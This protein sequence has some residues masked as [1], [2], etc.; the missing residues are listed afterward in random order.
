MLARGVVSSKPAMREAEATDPYR[1]DPEGVPLESV[2]VGVQQIETL[3]VAKVIPRD[4]LRQDPVLGNLRILVQPQGTVYDVSSEQNARLNELWDDIEPRQETDGPELPEPAATHLRERF[5]AAGR[6]LTWWKTLDRDLQRREEAL[7]EMQELLRRF[8]DGALDVE[9]FREEFDRRSRSRLW[10]EFGFGG[11]SGG[12][13]LNKLVKHLPHAAPLEDALRAAFAEPS[14]LDDA[15]SKL[16]QLGAFVEDAIQIGKATRL[17]LQ[18]ARLP[19]LTSAMWHIHGPF[20]W[21]ASYQSTRSQLGK[22]G[23][24]LG[25]DYGT[26]YRTFYNAE[27]AACHTLDIDSWVLDKLCAWS[28][29]KAAAQTASKSA[30]EPE[31]DPGAR[32][33]LIGSGHLDDIWPKMRDEKL[34]AI[35][36]GIGDLNQ[37]DSQESMK[38]AL[39]PLDWTS[40]NPTNDAKACW[41]FANEIRVGDKVIVKSG[42]TGVVAL[43]TLQSD[44]R[45]DES[46]PY[47]YIRD[48]TWDW[49]GEAELQDMKMVLKALTE[50]TENHALLE[51]VD[52]ATGKA[53]P[54]PSGPSGTFDMEDALRDL[55]MERSDLDMLRARLERKKNLV[56]QGPPGTGKTFVAA[57]LARLM[58]GEVSDER[59][60]RVQFHQS[61]GYEHF[62][63]GFRP[64]A[65]GGFEVR[66]GPFLDFCEQARQDQ[67][68]YW[69]VIIDEIN[70]GNL[71]RI[72]G[73]LL[74]LIE[75]D[76]RSEDWAVE[77]AYKRVR[78]W[79]P[80]N[81]LLIGTMN[82]ADR[83]L[84]LVDYAL[85]RRFAFS[86]LRPAFG[87]S[88]FRRH[89]VERTSDEAFVDRLVERLRAL[90]KLIV[91]DDELGHGFAVGHS[92]F[93]EP[94]G[95]L[96]AWYDD[97]VDSEILPLLREYWFDRSDAVERA[98]EILRRA[99]D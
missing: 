77:L 90:N 17:Q 15:V 37:Y 16:D 97:I 98:E 22:A 5:L 51:A 85:R 21:P 54:P 68:N 48:V 7:G 11:M 19:F 18:P 79:V 63:Q 1:V 91:G 42:R 49:L 29:P 26:F 84:A 62:V 78:F 4:A 32:I 52:Q 36:R 34:I 38:Q 10:R 70:R 95:E 75:G 57:R 30:P 24:P 73:E 59:V 27:R 61:Y 92:W 80:G 23:V 71:S 94:T 55:F 65:D 20:R 8:L 58:T 44:Y 2:R 33:W 28:P 93:C 45:Y 46:G 81:V 60:L 12:M 13:A 56:L 35:G 6:D 86:D 87:S 72:F 89:L 88:R 47:E 25:G 64:T 74:M 50:V 69:V 67:D 41:Q 31:P 14:D 96:E 3:P 39:I 83:S 82:T 53:P 40:D 99:E 76:K 43:G 9:E 66:R